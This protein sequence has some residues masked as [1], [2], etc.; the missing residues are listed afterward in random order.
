M[1]FFK[2]KLSPVE[3]L[4]IALKDKQVA[5][6]KLAIQLGAAKICLRKSGPRPDGWRLPALRTLSL[7]MQK[8]TCVR[9][10]SGQR[11]CAPRSLNSTSKS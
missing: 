7:R 10:M 9:S 11:R 4:E 1:A 2:R 3:R 8:L 6:Q 5:R